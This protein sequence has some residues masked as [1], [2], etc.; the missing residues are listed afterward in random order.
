[1][2]KIL[3]ILLVIVG[4]LQASAQKIISQ[5]N[6]S[7]LVVDYAQLL[8]P[9]QQSILEHKLVALDDS[10]SNQIVILTVRS[11]NGE[12]L[13]DVAVNTFRNWGIG[14]KKTKNGILVFIAY[15]DKKIRIEVG[16]GL[17][18][19]IPD[20]MA[21]DIINND[22]KPA[23]Q[24]KNYYN[25]LDKAADDLSKAAAGEYKIKRERHDDNESGGGLFKFIIIIIIIIII[26]S[27]RGGGGGMFI[28][29]F[30]GGGGGSGGGFSGGG[31]GGFGGFGGGSSSGGGASGSW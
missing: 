6:P 7:R 19:A 3:F 15:E 9:E 10:T 17:E 30:F 28:P 16:D 20:V 1:M 11:L 5:P 22:I 2:K 23:F 8:S 26:I 21:N 31:G 27:S 4:V 18:G 14:N 29:L 13:E 24:T 12:S 25:G